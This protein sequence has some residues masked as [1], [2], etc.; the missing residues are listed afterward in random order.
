MAAFIASYAGPTGQPRTV[1]IKA[2]NLA[3]AK[4]LLRRRG[5]RAEELRPVSAGNTQ[6]GNADLPQ[7]A[8]ARTSF[9]IHDF[10]AAHPRCRRHGTAA[11]RP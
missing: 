2:T 6:H 1:T 5:I 7:A 11:F 4:K 9:A 3:E 10:D 8:E